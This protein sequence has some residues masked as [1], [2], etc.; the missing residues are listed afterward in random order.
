MIILIGN[1][2]MAPEKASDAI[3]L[4]KKTLLIARKYKKIKIVSCVPTIH[5]PFITKQIKS[6]LFIGAQGVASSTEVAQTGLISPGMLKS[7]GAQYCI[8]GHSES[9]SRGETDDDVVAS[10]RALIQKKIVP[11][12]C[13]GE[14][15]RDAHGW[16]LSTVKGQIEKVILGI[17]KSQL[18]QILIAYE[19]IWAIGSSAVREA[20]TAECIEMVIFIRKVIADMVGEKESQKVT[21][22]YGGSVSEQN[23]ASFI[24]EGGAQGF[25]VGRASLD[26]RRFGLL[27]K[28]IAT[29]G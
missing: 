4:A 5:I 18:K 10:V 26:A 29:L 25:L 27:A 15:E 13:V 7:Y 14:R 21:I 20:T 22:L 3:S 11:V 9:R 2:K 6:T 24:T 12:V 8:V 23:A 1:W 19:P 17:Q 28:N 16:Y